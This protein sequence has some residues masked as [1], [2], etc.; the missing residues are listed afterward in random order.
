MLLFGAE[1]TGAEGRQ[2]VQYNIPDVVHLM[3]G[4][5][6]KTVQGHA[7]LLLCAVE[8]LIESLADLQLRMRAAFL[9]RLP[10]RRKGIRG[11]AGHQQDLSV[12][13]CRCNMCPL[14]EGTAAG[15]HDGGGMLG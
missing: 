10:Q 11:K 6:F 1:E 8:H 5:F 3:G 12:Q 2:T 7:V 13:L 15:D 9:Q 4:R 14:P